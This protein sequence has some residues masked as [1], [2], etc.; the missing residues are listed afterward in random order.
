MLNVTTPGIILGLIASLGRNNLD[1]A[2]KV[3]APALAFAIVLALIVHALI[4]FG[5][6]DALRS[7]LLVTYIQTISLYS[8]VFGLTCVALSLSF[9]R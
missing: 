3:A 2:L 8:L 1:A 9:E 4:A 6:R 7:R 5:Q